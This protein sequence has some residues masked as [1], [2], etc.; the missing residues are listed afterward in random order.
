M[1][2]PLRPDE[3][4]QPPDAP[5]GKPAPH[6][7]GADNS[8]VS[9]EAP[10]ATGPSQATGSAA[11]TP[12]TQA[13]MANLRAFMSSSYARG[14][15]EQSRIAAEA[16]RPRIDAAM[17]TAMRNIHLPTFDVLSANR[18]TMNS[19]AAKLDAGRSALGE[20][21][22]KQ[23]TAYQQIVRERMTDA[24]ALIER[25]RPAITAFLVEQ[26]RAALEARTAFHWFL[27]RELNERGWW[28]VP[29][30]DWQFLM[31]L[32]RAMLERRGSR[33]VDSFLLRYYR[34]NRHRAL[35]RAIRSWTEPEFADRLKIFR[36]A[37]TDYRGKRYRRVIASLTPHVEGVI[38]DFLVAE[39]A[40]AAARAGRT[41]TPTLVR[42]H[43]TSGLRHAGV[44][45]FTATIELMFTDFVWGAP[46]NTRITRH[47]LS[48]GAVVPPNSERHSLRLFLMFDTLHFFLA[49]VRRRRR[50]AAS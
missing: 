14:L 15:L 5:S 40:L 26:A 22:M 31:A 45:G 11:T 42:T 39:G 3:P 10:R 16:A 18:D 34:G 48:H 46:S 19:V 27:A 35:S 17:L 9:D 37:F 43:L 13:M 6:P 38:K 32:S 12:S 50:S 29:T 23:V 1:P 21:V 20:S 33:V 7:A 36:E 41:S 2:E 24:Q 4:P 44:P 49:D 30:W 28:L 8:A 25:A 47:P